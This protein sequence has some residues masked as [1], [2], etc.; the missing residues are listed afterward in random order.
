M[1]DL[2][3]MDSYLP[4]WGLYG[5]E[6]FG[7]DS[8]QLYEEVAKA[9]EATGVAHA[10][11]GPGANALGVEDLSGTLASAEIKDKQLHFWRDIKKE[12]AYSLAVEWA[13]LDD[14][15]DAHGAPGFI[16][17]SDSGFVSD[18]Q[19]Y[20]GVKQVKYLAVK[21]QVNL[22]TQLIEIV[23]F[24]GR[25]KQAMDLSEEIKMLELLRNAERSLFFGDSNTC[26]LEWDGVFR[27][28]DDA[29]NT[30]NGI[31]L[32]LRGNA[33]DKDLI[34]YL[35]QIVGNN[36]A[37]PTHLYVPNEAL[38]DLRQSL[39]PSQRMG[40]NYVEGAVGAQFSRFLIEAIGGDPDYVKV[41]RTQMLTYGVKGGL[42]LK[43]TGVKATAAPSAPATVA[44]AAAA[45]TAT[46]YRPGLASDTYLYAVCAVGKAGRSLHTAAGA[47]VAP[48]AGQKVTLTIT[49]GAGSGTL[50]YEVY[51]NPAGKAATAENLEF[52]TRV[53]KTDVGA[54]TTWDDDGYALP[55]CYHMGLFSIQFDEI[56][57]KQLLPVVKRVLPQDLMANSYGILLF[58]TPIVKVPT[59]NI[60]VVNVGRRPQAGL[61]SALA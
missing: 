28:I 16:S 44:S 22:P 15:S 1:S 42:P 48:T 31:R 6:N 20:R 18:P 60:H 57:F 50:F 39:F 51:R 52:V 36:S 21:G 17:G 55:G 32:D 5:L 23:G 30:G 33:P 29:A 10:P 41:R 8:R 61:P 38:R 12:E 2:I 19:F 25:G 13:R 43:L 26:S 4:E 56:V 45:H 14:A 7:V 9:L 58:G 54:D 47:T 46:S 11:S 24:R 53:K 27:Q 34:E 40:E 49:E 3:T 37:D 59:H 35:V